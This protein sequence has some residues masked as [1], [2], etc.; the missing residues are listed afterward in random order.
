MW[1]L[2]NSPIHGTRMTQ[3]TPS[4]P[5]RASLDH[6]ELLAGGP[7]GVSVGEVSMRGE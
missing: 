1:C 4:K 5:K 2:S 3:R 6:P 7:R